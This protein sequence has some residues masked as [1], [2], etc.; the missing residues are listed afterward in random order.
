MPERPSELAELSFRDLIASDEVQLI[1]EDGDL[2]IAGDDW[3]LVLEG[4]PV[5][6][7]L[8]ALD[9]EDGP[10]EQALRNAIN[11][12]ALLSM[13]DLN[14]RMEGELISILLNSPDIVARALAELL[15]P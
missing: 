5:T 6:D 13:V 8:V 1:K 9:D 12:A 10:P 15:E 14:G 2:H 3:T 7:A 11:D 4:D